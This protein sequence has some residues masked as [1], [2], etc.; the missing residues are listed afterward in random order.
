[1]NSDVQHIIEKIDSVLFSQTAV[2]ITGDAFCILML[3]CTARWI[4]S[5]IDK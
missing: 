1:M 3:F 2:S 4:I 5:K